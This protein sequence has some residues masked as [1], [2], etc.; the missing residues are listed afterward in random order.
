MFFSIVGQIVGESKYILCRCEKVWRSGNGG[1]LTHIPTTPTLSPL[2]HPPLVYPYICIYL[3]PYIPTFVTLVYTDILDLFVILQSNNTYV[4]SPLYG[5]P[6]VLS[7]I[8]GDLY[9]YVLNI[10]SPLLYSYLFFLCFLRN[11]KV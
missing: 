2:C 6:Y 1:Y 5:D 8:Y 4:L 7:S 9:P 10:Y 11:I 3:Y